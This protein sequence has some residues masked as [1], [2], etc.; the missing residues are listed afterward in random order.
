MQH[1]QSCQDPVGDKWKTAFLIT[2]GQYEYLVMPFGLRNAPSTF[3]TCI[4]ILRDVM[5][6]LFVIA[7]IDYILIYLTNLAIHVQHVNQV[8]KDEKCKFHLTSTSFLG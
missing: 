5:L 6:V 1:L 4:K 7:Y 8:L 2:T 3:L